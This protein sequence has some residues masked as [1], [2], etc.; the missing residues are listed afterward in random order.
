MPPPHRDA[1][2]N[3]KTCIRQGSKSLDHT[4][5]SKTR[6]R[7]SPAGPRYHM[8][9]YIS[10]FLLLPRSNLQSWRVSRFFLE[11]ITVSRVSFITLHDNLLGVWIRTLP[12][13]GIKKE[14]LALFL[15]EGGRTVCRHR[16][17]IIPALEQYFASTSFTC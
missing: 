16:R 3:P 10:C 12:A 11:I 15:V 13:A 1:S 17:P 9:I 5:D 8:P 2:I 6:R 14:H 4:H 7:G